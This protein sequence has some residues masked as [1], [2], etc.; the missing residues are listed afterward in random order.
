[1][2]PVTYV[3]YMIQCNDKSFYVGMT[4]NIHKRLWQHKNNKEAKFFR[5]KNKLPITL[6]YQVDFN[7][8]LNAIKY[9]KYLK[10]LNKKRKLKLVTG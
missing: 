10:K 3:V 5:R 7:S 2:N 6:I 8:K 1:M 9:E 4:N